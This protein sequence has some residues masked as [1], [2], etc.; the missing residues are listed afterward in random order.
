VLREATRL[1]REGRSAEA[2]S[3]LRR[4][5]AEG[6]L[7]PAKLGNAG[8]F[9]QKAIAGGDLEARLQVLVLGQLT[10]NYL[11]Q[12]LSAVAWSEGVALELREG[13]YDT[14]LQ[15]LL[16]L[17]TAP[18]VVILLP[19]TQRLLAAGERSLSARIDDELSFWGQAWARVEALGSRLVQVGYDWTGPGPGGYASGETLPLIREAE[20]ALRAAAP[21]GTFWVDLQG[22]AGELGRRSF[23]DPRSYH[24]TKQPF[25]TEGVA[26]LAQHLWAG[27]RAL[28]T[29]PKKVLVLDLDN[30]LWGGVVGEEGPRSVR[31]GGE[32]P[33][34]A[35]YLAFQRHALR[36][37]QRG[38]VLAVCSKNNLADAKEPFE[39]NPDMALSLSDFAAFEAS[40]DPK[41]VAIAR[42]AET[43]RLGLDAF[44]FFDDN[45]VERAE[46][47]AALPQ[48]A[49][50][51]APSDPAD[52]VRVLESGLYFEAARV[53]EADRQRAQQYQAEAQRREVHQS[54]V[55]LDDYLRSLDMRG[56]AAPVE[57]PDLPRV[58]QLI[59]KTNQFNLTTRRH[60][61]GEVRR[62]LADERTLHLALRLH[63]RF[64]DYG[65]IGVVLGVPLEGE[66]TTCR[67]DTWLM[68]CRAI[69][70]GVEDFT[71]NGVADAAR[72]LGYE[73]LLGEFRQSA[74]NAPVADL[75]S[76]FGFEPAGEH[77]GTHRFRL[78]LA[79]FSG[80]QTFVQDSR[81][82]PPA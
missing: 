43:L 48:V 26:W 52:Y 16:A 80:A 39:V 77:E 45:P 79:S 28:T 36:L 38:V 74:K 70:R 34:G 61:E 20:S 10:T 5:L 18:D 76:R 2:L 3:L 17:E 47:R 25:S 49:V 75:F 37:S 60:S 59:A 55:S 13:D 11:A 62:L 50:V 81:D 71:L 41:S 72:A 19:W 30:T 66:P 82:S 22:A 56:H 24:W 68:S 33:E 35:A 63:D 40:W 78:E 21:S 32:Q 44:V 14:V 51:E 29:G 23:Y 15:T 67:L 9:V 6:A 65:L 46:V 8:R 12:A 54:A 4:A 64:G 57:E 69:G 73:S 42:I 27:V 31:V 53:Q 1:R 58:V 7:P